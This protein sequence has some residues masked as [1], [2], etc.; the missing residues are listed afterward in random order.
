MSEKRI[1]PAFVNSVMI[2]GNLTKDPEHRETKA[3]APV[4][5]MRIATSRKFRAGGVLKEETCFANIV[6]WDRLSLQCS[7][8]GIK[9]GDCLFIQGRLQSKEWTASDGSSRSGLEIVA[10][11]IQF[12][13][14]EYHD[15]N[16]EDVEDYDVD[17][18]PDL[19]DDNEPVKA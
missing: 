17:E 18:I 7:K 6:A 12:L 14:V 19:E 3:G 11:K 8:F 1:R 2:T 4:T 15:R 16:Q 9:K 5:N 10:E 13:T